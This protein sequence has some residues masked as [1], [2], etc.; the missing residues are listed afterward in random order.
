MHPF[1]YNSLLFPKILRPLSPLP[2]VAS[3]PIVMGSPL[4]VPVL[5]EVG[6]SKTVDL[7][8]QAPGL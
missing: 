5:S 1:S 7:V 3:S 8:G 4:V 2:Q 6:S